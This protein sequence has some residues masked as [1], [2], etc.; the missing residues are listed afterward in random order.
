MLRVLQV[1]LI[2]HERMVSGVG[3]HVLNVSKM[4]KRMGHDVQIFSSNILKEGTRKTA[5][6]FQEVEGV[7]V[8]HFNA[9]KIPKMT[10]GYVPSPS[11]IRALLDWD[12]DIVHA[13]SYSYF[14]TYTSAFARLF[15]ERPLVLTT[16]QPPM[17][18]AFKSRFLMKVYNRSLGRLSLRKADKIIA[19]TKLE[20]DFLVNV[21]GADPNKIKVIP[22]GVDLD[23]FKPSRTKLESERVILFVGRIAPEKGLIYLVKAVP[24]V[25]SVFPSMPILI[26]GED[27]GIQKH[28]VK[29]A[30]KLKVE[31][32]VHFLGPKFGYELART[33]QKARIFV[34]PSLYE[35]FGLAILEAMATGL[36]VVATR[37][38]GIP[39]LVEDGRNGILI[40][41]RDHRALAEAIIELLSDRE[42][43]LKISERNTKKAKRYSWKSIAARV[44]G[45][46]KDLCQQ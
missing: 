18:T 8:R 17:E 37:V 40:S 19:T 36:P 4:L 33:Y 23:L 14:P 15:K 25:A 24:R 6:E 27:Q 41:P 46:Y 32:I 28:L 12:A 30:E 16:H 31:K 20:A 34:L 10:S 29:V 39:E 45:V 44:E 3:L 35:T 1:C 13:H 9:F 7:R 11:F 21:A 2:F 26:V 43:S 42:L 38:G 5:P 22:E